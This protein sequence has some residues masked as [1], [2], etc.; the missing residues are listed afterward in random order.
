MK[1]LF[2]RLDLTVNIGKETFYVFAEKVEG[3]YLKHLMFLPDTLNVF[4]RKSLMFL[5]NGG[6]YGN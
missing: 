4:A 5:Q 1:Y 2:R 3:F 6:E